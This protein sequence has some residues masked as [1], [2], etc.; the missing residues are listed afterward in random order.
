M[1]KKKKNIKLSFILHN[2]SHKVIMRTVSLKIQ[3]VF[4]LDL[5][6]TKFLE[7]NINQS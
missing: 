6:V 2:C 7:I 1:I 5:E 4:R 3:L